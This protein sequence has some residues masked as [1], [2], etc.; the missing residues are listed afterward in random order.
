MKYFVPRVIEDT[1]LV[2]GFSLGTFDDG[3]EIPGVEVLRRS[4]AHFLNYYRSRTRP[5]A[6][7]GVK[8]AP[9]ITPVLKRISNSG[10]DEP[11]LRE[12]Q[13]DVLGTTV[14]ASQE[15]SAALCHLMPED[16]ELLPVEVENARDCVWIR[17]PLIP[18][19]LNAE[20]SSA[21]PPRVIERPVLNKS[22]LKDVHILSF[23][24]R[25]LMPAVSEEFVQ[26]VEKNGFYGLT[27]R[28]I[29]VV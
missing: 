17:P 24:E 8:Q 27:F 14:L 7:F 9:W 28:E 5:E 19:A 13:L 12:T 25:Y 1:C 10:A 4:G 22:A 6:K 18:E 21:S 16:A 20:L 11:G 3:L 23:A 26:V 15:A 2:L 29:D